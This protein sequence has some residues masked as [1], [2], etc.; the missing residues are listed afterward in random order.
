MIWMIN[1]EDCQK[2]G[3]GLILRINPVFSWRNLRKVQ[4]SS[5]GFRIEKGTL[6]LQNT[7]QYILSIGTEF[8]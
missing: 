4:A 5:A 2:A 3:R 7:M 1:S 6:N 8:H